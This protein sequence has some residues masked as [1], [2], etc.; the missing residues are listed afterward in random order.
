MACEVNWQRAFDKQRNRRDP[1]CSFDK[2][3]TANLDSVFENNVLPRPA[4]RT[5][6]GGCAR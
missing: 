1:L 4:T 6:F 5:I 3:D 2:S